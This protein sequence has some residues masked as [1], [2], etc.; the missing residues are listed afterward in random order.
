MPVEEMSAADLSDALKTS[1]VQEKIWCILEQEAP[2]SNDLLA[3]RLATSCGNMKLTAKV[4]E[5]TDYHCRN[6][7]I[8]G[9]THGD[10]TFWW[11]RDQDPSTYSW[12]RV[13]G[14]ASTRRSASDIPLEE[15][16]NAVVYVVRAGVG[17]P[18]D[19][20]AKDSAK[21]MGYSR[22]NA[23]LIAVFEA[24]LTECINRDILKEG[25][26]GNIVVS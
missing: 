11:N 25:P 15:A 20:V 12:I 16:M 9:T 7:K 10:I 19:S 21:L 1:M 6:A 2:I 13:A 23:D 14:D 5:R 3:R 4:K 17:V 22:T 26:G 24:A 8:Q 18:K